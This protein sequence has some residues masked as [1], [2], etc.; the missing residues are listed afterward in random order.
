MDSI[1]YNAP[2]YL[3]VKSAGNNRGETG[4]AVG[5]PYFRFNAQNQMTAA[6]T[7]PSSISSNDS[8]GTITWDG[9]AKNILTVGAVRGI[10]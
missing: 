4:P 10:P 6:G 8:Y 3:I 2:F 9:N 5:E 1:A 7:R